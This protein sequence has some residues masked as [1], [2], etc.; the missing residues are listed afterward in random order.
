MEDLDVEREKD[1]VWLKEKF[2]Y[3]SVEFLLV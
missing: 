1:N 3:D 2:V